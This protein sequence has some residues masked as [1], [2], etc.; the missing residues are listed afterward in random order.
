MDEVQGICEALVHLTITGWLEAYCC[1]SV[2]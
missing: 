2:L 1:W